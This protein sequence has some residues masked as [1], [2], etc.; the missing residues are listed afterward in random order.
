MFSEMERV[1]S[2]QPSLLPGGGGG[3]DICSLVSQTLSILQHPIVSSIWDGIL[4]A[5]TAVGWNG[6]GLQD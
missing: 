4:E 6:S 2:V 5:I 1:V 3:V